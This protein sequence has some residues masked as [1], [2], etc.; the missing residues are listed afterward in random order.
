MVYAILD[1]ICKD[2]DL[3]PY[4][5]KFKMC[6]DGTGLYYTI[7]FRWLNPNHMI[8]MALEAKAAL[9][10]LTYDREMKIWNW[11]SMSHVM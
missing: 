7:Y 5:K 11:E 3:Y 1:L 4:V 8:S 9:Q 10:T 2:T 6:H